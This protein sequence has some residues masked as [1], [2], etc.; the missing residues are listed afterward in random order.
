MSSLLFQ[1]SSRRG[2]PLSD[3]QVPSHLRGLLEASIGN[4]VKLLASPHPMS[5]LRS[6]WRR[7]QEAGARAVG[8]RLLEQLD[9]ALVSATGALPLQTVRSLPTSR[10]P[11]AASMWDRAAREGATGGGSGGGVSPRAMV[12]SAT[13]PTRRQSADGGKGRSTESGSPPLPE[14]RLH[15][16]GHSP[17]GRGPRPLHGPFYSRAAPPHPVAAPAPAPVSHGVFLRSS[18]LTQYGPGS[19]NARMSLLASMGASAHQR[20]LAR[21]LASVQSVALPHGGHATVRGGSGAQGGA[22][23]SAGANAAARLST[24]QRGPS[25]SAHRA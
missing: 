19:A 18:S 2:I 4:Q 24:S 9:T 25:Q 23:G 1:A 8:G 5:P 21:V 17:S 10:A 12:T 3:G 11:R 16:P 22:S 7:G 14:G 20:S 15:G 6:P 13:A